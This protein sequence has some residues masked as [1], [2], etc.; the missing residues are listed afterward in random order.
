MLTQGQASDLAGFDALSSKIKADIVIGDKGYDADAKVREL[1]QKVGKTAVI[2]PKSNRKHPETYAYDKDL[3][4]KRHKIENFFS[5]LKDFRSIA[6]RYE[7]TSRNFLV[8]I[9]LAAAMIWLN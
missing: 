5:R 2:L 1:L 4:K 3:H 8:G 9:H 7:K 6:T